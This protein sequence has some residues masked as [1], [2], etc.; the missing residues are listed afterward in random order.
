VET[1]KKLGYTSN[2]TL[3]YWDHWTSKLKSLRSQMLSQLEL[4]QCIATIRSHYPFV[5]KE[6]V[7][8]A[9]AEAQGSIEEATAKLSEEEFLRECD[10]I[11]RVINVGKFIK[12]EGVGGLFLDRE[13]GV[14]DADGFSLVSSLDNGS[15]I[16]VR[17]EGSVREELYEGDYTEVDRDLGSG[18]DPSG[19]CDGDESSTSSV[20]HDLPRKEVEKIIQRQ[21]EQSSPPPRTFASQTS[22]MKSLATPESSKSPV[23][24]MVECHIR[25][26]FVSPVHTVRLNSIINSGSGE[27]GPQKGGRIAG[28]KGGGFRRQKH[29]LTI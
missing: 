20:S 11:C 21:R 5:S 4:N 2:Q 27:W 12:I 15:S 1:F 19:K 8:V 29:K 22:F 18:R 28:G 13:E 10:V 6:A 24:I 3:V 17:G 14:V 23:D 9:L 26:N 25:E 7:F 16:G